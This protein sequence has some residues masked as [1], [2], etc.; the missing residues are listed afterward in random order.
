MEYTHTK[1]VL[2]VAY[3]TF[4]W[5]WAGL[6]SAFYVVTQDGELVFIILA[7]V[8]QCSVKWMFGGYMT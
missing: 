2:C 3:L 1:S 8:E 5:H 6:L 7:A 4:Q